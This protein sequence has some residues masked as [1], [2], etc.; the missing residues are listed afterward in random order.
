MYN[1]MRKLIF[2]LI[3]VI[4]ATETYA[5]REVH[6]TLFTA[7]GA[8]DTTVYRVFKKD[9]VY[10]ELDVTTLANNDTVTIGGSVDRTALIPMSTDFPLKLVKAD[11]IS[12]VNGALGKFT[13][14]R[15]G[16]GNGSDSWNPKYLGIRIKSAGA[17]KPSLH[18]NP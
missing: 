16:V 8:I 1:K 3:V 9:M 5:Q 10:F 18:W 6:D 4:L 15:I 17:C 14:Y 11:L 2:I 13:K 7:A 12:I